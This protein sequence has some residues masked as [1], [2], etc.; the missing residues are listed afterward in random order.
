M[1]QANPL[2]R[3]AAYLFL[4]SFSPLNATELDV[5][6]W[7]RI[8]YSGSEYQQPNHQLHHNFTIWILGL[9]RVHL[10]GRTLR[11]LTPRGIKANLLGA[12]GFQTVTDLILKDILMA[13]ELEM[14]NI[15]E[16][17]STIEDCYQD[18]SE[19]NISLVDRN[20]SH[21]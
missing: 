21:S 11:E 1:A 13:S 15:R 19:A 9:S 2:P 14:V 18:H 17:V 7:A 8:W 3:G 4:R 5:Q 10:T 6:D 12:V 16:R 20:E